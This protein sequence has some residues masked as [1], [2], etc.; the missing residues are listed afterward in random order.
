MALV[1]PLFSAG[2][3]GEVVGFISRFWPLIAS[4]V[5]AR[6]ASFIEESMNSTLIVLGLL[7]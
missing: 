1:D 4:L 5:S 2:K 7:S 3:S 6:T